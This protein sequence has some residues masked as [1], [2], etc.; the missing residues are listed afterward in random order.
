MAV[1]G[2]AFY[3]HWSTAPPATPLPSGKAWRCETG[4]HARHRSERRAVDCAWEAAWADVPRDERPWR[5]V[6][7]GAG[8]P[9]REASKP[10][11]PWGDA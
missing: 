9:C 2:Q 8:T 5:V 7:I 1:L 3:I 11:A 4:R 10:V 6:S